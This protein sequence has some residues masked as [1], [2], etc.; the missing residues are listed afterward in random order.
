[1]PQT[2][3][4]AV[5]GC[6]GGSCDRLAFGSA[7]VTITGAP[8]RGSPQRLDIGDQIVDFRAGQRQIGHLSMRMGKPCAQL[9]GVEMAGGDAKARRALRQDG[10]GTAAVDDV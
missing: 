1:M 9:P 6:G 2:G 10:G 7:T 5:P 3:S 8:V 4:V